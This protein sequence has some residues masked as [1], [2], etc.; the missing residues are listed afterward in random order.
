[1]WVF[2]SGIVVFLSS[3]GEMYMCA[4]GNYFR[5]VGRENQY[6]LNNVLVKLLSIRFGF[7]QKFQMNLV[8]LIA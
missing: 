4:Q 7:S 8:I 6:K 5:V 1:M 3:R 2:V